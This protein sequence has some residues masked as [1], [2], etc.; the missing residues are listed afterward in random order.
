MKPQR[1]KEQHILAAQQHSAAWKESVIEDLYHDLGQPGS[2]FPCIFA[3]SALRRKHL[4]FA[5]VESMRDT[6]TWQHLPSV[7]EEYVRVYR[8]IAQHTAFVVV[9]RPTLTALDLDTY[10]ETFWRLLAFLHQHDPELWPEHIP[11]GPDDPYWEFCFT[12]EPIF[13]VCNTPEHKGRRSPGLTVTMQ[14][15]GIF[16]GL[17]PHTEA[18]K[19]A[20]WIT[21]KRLETYD[22]AVISPYLG[23]YGDPRARE[24]RQYFL[25]DDNERHPDVCPFAI[26]LRRSA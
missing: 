13:L 20:R 18:G 14:P 16:D 26:K 9:F 25:Y 6:K 19:Q 24:W 8:S 4:R 21:R 17:E 10:T 23:D 7:V 12:G 2:A 3:V 15:R 5:F 22:D 1:L 11:V